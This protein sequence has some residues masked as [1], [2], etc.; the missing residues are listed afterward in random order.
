VARRSAF[1]LALLSDEPWI[2]V[3]AIEL[4]ETWSTQ[5]GRQLVS[6]AILDD[7]IAIATHQSDGPPES[8]RGT[9]HR[10][11]QQ[12]ALRVMRT[13][14][15]WRDGRFSPGERRLAGYLGQRIDAMREAVDR[16]LTSAGVAAFIQRLSTA[17]IGRSERPPP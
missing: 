16:G 12:I 13:V 4:F 3:N 2:L 9:H 7:L 17:N 11:R 6:Q 10:F 1:E 15:Q 8:V 14:L 5:P